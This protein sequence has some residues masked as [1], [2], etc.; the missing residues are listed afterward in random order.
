MT[1]GIMKIVD[2]RP[3]IGSEV[4][5]DKSALMSGRC[6]G[7]LLALL[8]QRGVIVMRGI[9]LSDDEE[10]ELAATMGT[11]RQ[12]F[13]RPIMRVTMDRSANKD[14][15]D[16]FHATFHWHMDGTY[17]DVP[18]LASILTPRVLPPVG[19]GQT[20]FS[21]TYAAWDDLSETDKARL[22]S[23]EIVH[24]SVFA[25]PPDEQP[26]AAQLERIARLGTRTHP[27]V[28]HHRSGRISLALGDSAE[29]IVGMEKTESDAMLRWLM[30]WMTRPD[31]VYRHEWRMG[32]V[33]MWDN[34]GTLHR[35]L[36]YDK[37]CGRRLHRVT[38]VGEESISQ[39]A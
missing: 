19:T 39:A 14:H 27:L 3:R 2:L 13:G 17:E 5:I 6:A 22:S 37:N 38:L 16:Y 10:I 21:N 7:D 1:Q 20:E 24:S 28:W 31:Y 35:A 23:L 34:T 30:G 25:L 15:V 8:E 26:T 4:T 32:D 9:E 33:L 36:P 18:P 11:I 12:D 29:R